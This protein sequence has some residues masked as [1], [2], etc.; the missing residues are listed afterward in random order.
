MK[1]NEVE[2][3]EE[4]KWD[5]RKRSGMKE[6]DGTKRNK[7]GRKEM[8]WDKWKQSKT[9]ENEMERN[10]RKWSGTNETK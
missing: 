7:I 10:E 5:E 6:N 4:T 9:K 2:Q 1:E 3:T 8:K